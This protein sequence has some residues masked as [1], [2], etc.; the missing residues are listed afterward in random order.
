[1]LDVVGPQ[2]ALLYQRWWCGPVVPHLHRLATCDFLPR[3]VTQE[4]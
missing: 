1:L 4:Q 3:P 2:Q